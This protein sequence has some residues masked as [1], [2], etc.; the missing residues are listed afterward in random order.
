MAAAASITPIKH[1]QQETLTPGCSPSPS[2]GKIT[3][4][5]AKT[6]P[7]QFSSSISSPEKKNGLIKQEMLKAAST[8][9]GT[10]LVVALP[11]TFLT[12]CAIGLTFLAPSLLTFL[13]SFTLL[14][15]AVLLLPV[16]CLHIWN[17]L[18]N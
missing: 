16:C 17:K 11:I 7:S 12:V 1:Q 3:K 8:I 6:N 4:A 15:L 18:K 5:F 2:D 13:L 14:G 10:F 9:F